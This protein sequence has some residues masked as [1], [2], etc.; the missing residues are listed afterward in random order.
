MIKKLNDDAWKIEN[1]THTPIDVARIYGGLLFTQAS[2]SP[3]GMLWSVALDHDNMPDI[4]RL[5]F[6]EWDEWRKNQKN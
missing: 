1:S 2:P 6:Q 3:D 4:I 5:L